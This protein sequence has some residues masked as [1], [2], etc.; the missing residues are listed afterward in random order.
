MRIKRNI[1]S[2]LSRLSE[3][4][5]RIFKINYEDLTT[6]IFYDPQQT[7]YLQVCRDMQCQEE[8]LF[9][10]EITRAQAFHIMNTRN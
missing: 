10:R 4:A 2:R 1:S 8:V 9:R 7:F 3:K 6:Q 5:K